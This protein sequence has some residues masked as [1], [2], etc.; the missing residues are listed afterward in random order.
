M[1]RR[2]FLKGLGV[3]L[4]GLPFLRVLEASAA[5]TSP[6]RFVGIY[7]PH[8]ATSSLY[9]MR[10]GETET[11]FDLAYPNCVL[12]P[13]D[14]F[15]SRLLVLEGVDLSAAI[16]A[17]KTGHDAPSSMFTGCGGKPVN[18][19]ID[20]HLA[21]NAG[22]GSATRV[23]SL[24]LAVGYDLPDLT[25]SISYG[26]GGATLSKL[27]DPVQTFSTLFSGFVP[28][29]PA[30]DTQ[31][32][33]RIVR[34]WQ[35]GKSVLDFQKADL[36]RL[37]ARLAAPEKL[38]LEQHSEALRDLEK[39]LGEMPTAVPPPQPV[40]CTVPARPRTF[41][42]VRSWNSGEPNFEEITN[43]QI[44]L[45]AQ[46]MACDVTRFST[47]LLNDLSRGATAGTGLTGLPSDCHADLA[48]Q[49]SVSSAASQ[50]ALGK[51]HRYS[52]SKCARLLQRC[53]E[54]GIVDD[55]GVLMMSDMGDPSAH[56]SR[57]VPT[58]LAGGWGGKLR[59]GRRLK[60]PNVSNARVLVSV[61]QAFGLSGVTSY[62]NGPGN[63]GA[64]AE[65]R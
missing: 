16:A 51:Q 15:K 58:V 59:M 37:N 10:P 29:A 6:M 56:S 4:G 54:L 33:E 19:S 27:I 25:S 38:K 53:T 50:V 2:S 46:A 42:A 55:V 60:L 18:P 5:G 49:Y 14:A 3:A 12:Q 62:G 43:L 48:H 31:A 21:V 30:G 63:S 64:I 22:L 40:T 61:T 26:A 1:R 41:S 32:Q 11:Q 17:G 35:Q 44:D 23:T 13:L 57:N 45:L 36:A 39:R 20:R 9:A 65:L 24:A 34:Q 7:H 8:G 28:P 52:Y 47:L